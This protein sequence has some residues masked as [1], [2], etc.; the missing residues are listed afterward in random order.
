MISLISLFEA[1]KRFGA[2]DP[3][4]KLIQKR[5]ADIKDNVAKLQEHY[6]RVM[7]AAGFGQLVDLVIH[8]I[9]S[10]LGKLGREVALIE[11]TLRR[12]RSMS[13]Q[14]EGNFLSCRTWIEEIANLR[15]KLLPRAAGYRGKA[16]VFDVREEIASNIELFHAIIT[17]RGIR[18]LSLPNDEAS[19]SVK[20]PRSSFGQVI[21]NLI[22]NSIYWVSTR[23]QG[24]P[25][26]RIHVTTER[27]GDTFSVL[28]SDNGPGIQ[29]ENEAKIFD[30]QF[31]TKPHGMGMGLF[32]ARQ[33]IEP[34]GRLLYEREG[35]L[36]GANFRAIFE[37]RFTFE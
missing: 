4:A 21:A 20:M 18:W 29:P 22:D 32:V 27:S 16:Q 37:K 25:G 17:K 19:F 5:D 3:I 15:E 23:Y 2:S 28:V 36:D 10:P 14:I 26:G 11:K 30:L 8:E 12:T 24:K 33:V 34:Y 6:S 9:G 7:L 13:D 1:K 31:S 35:P